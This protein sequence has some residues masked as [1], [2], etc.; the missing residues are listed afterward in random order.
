MGLEEEKSVVQSRIVEFMKRMKE[1]EDV[2]LTQEDKSQ[3]DG[4][5]KQIF[6]EILDIDPDEINEDSHLA[7][8]LEMDSLAFL[9]MFDEFKEFL[10]LELDVN[11][12]A[13][14]SQDHPAET[15]GDFM[16]QIFTF[17]E[18]PDEVLKELG[19]DKEEMMS[20]V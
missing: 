18:R 12:V 4:V 2:K 16:D 17:I 13:K 3:I 20:Q 6:A 8:D 10:N 11:T 5:M 7:D 1:G 14:Y 19:I 15:Y 9:E